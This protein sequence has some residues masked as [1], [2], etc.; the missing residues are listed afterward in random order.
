[1]SLLLWIAAKVVGV[2]L[3]LFGIFLVVFFPGIG[4][5]GHQPDEFGK[6]G[7]LIGLVLL[8]IGIYLLFV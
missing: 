4:G 8:L 3:V 1:M 7:I 6:T 2:L 5:K